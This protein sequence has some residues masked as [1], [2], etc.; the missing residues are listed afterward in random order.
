MLPLTVEPRPAQ[1]TR[2]FVGRLEIV[3]PD[4]LRVVSD[5]LAR[6][7]QTTLERQ[8]RFLQ[9][10]ARRLLDTFP[11]VQR[12]MIEKRLEVAVTTLS[13]STTICR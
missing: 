1:T 13:A 2:V 10:I 7:D 5:A 3:S 4:T 9:P 8:G 12:T 11:A 6:N